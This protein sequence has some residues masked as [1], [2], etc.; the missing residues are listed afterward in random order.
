M[1]QA[2]D[3][4]YSSAHSKSPAETGGNQ[5]LTKQEFAAFFK[6]HYLGF[7]RGNF[8]LRSLLH[9]HAAAVSQICPSI[10][11]TQHVLLP[12]GAQIPGLLTDVAVSFWSATRHQLANKREVDDSNSLVHSERMRFVAHFMLNAVESFAAANQL[13]DR[14]F[15]ATRDNELGLQKKED[16]GSLAAALELR[17]QSFPDF[18]TP[19]GKA[20]YNGEVDLIQLQLSQQESSWQQHILN[21]RPKVLLLQS[22]T[23]ISGYCEIGTINGKAATGWGYP[24][25][26][27]Q[28]SSK[29]DSRLV[30]CTRA[31]YSICSKHINPYGQF[32]LPCVTP[33][34][35]AQ[36][37]YQGNHHSFTPL[38]V[39]HLSKAGGFLSQ[40]EDLYSAAHLVAHYIATP[41]KP[42]Q[43]NQ[44]ISADSWTQIF[45][46]SEDQDICALEL[47]LQKLVLALRHWGQNW[48]LLEA[49][50]V[51]YC[52]LVLEHL[53]LDLLAEYGGSA[54]YRRELLENMMSSSVAFDSM[55]GRMLKSAHEDS[56][57]NSGISY[58]G[59]EPDLLR[60]MT[61]FLQP[62]T[63][64]EGALEESM[65]ALIGGQQLEP[66]KGPSVLQEAE[67]L[68]F[69]EVTYDWLF[70]I[71]SGSVDNDVLDYDCVEDWL[72]SMHWD[73]SH[74]DATILT[75]L[76]QWVKSQCSHAGTVERTVFQ[77]LHRH[78]FG[79]AQG[80]KSP[81]GNLYMGAT[82]HYAWN[83]LLD[84]VYESMV[85][86]RT[87]SL[88][89][90]PVCYNPYQAKFTT[91]KELVLHYI[92]SDGHI[93]EPLRSH[94]RYIKNAASNVER[95]FESTFFVS[96]PSKLSHAHFTGAWCVKPKDFS[97]SADQL[98]ELTTGDT[99]QTLCK[100]DVPDQNKFMYFY[101]G[102]RFITHLIKYLNKP[103]IQRRDYSAVYRLLCTLRRMRQG[104]DRVAM[105]T[106]L[107]RRDQLTTE[108]LTWLP[109]DDALTDDDAVYAA[110][111]EARSVQFQGAIHGWCSRTARGDASVPAE[112]VWFALKALEGYQ[113]A[114]RFHRGEDAKQAL[115]AAEKEWTASAN[116]L[117][118]IVIDG[119][120][121]ASVPPICVA[122]V[123]SQVELAAGAAGEAG[124]AQR[125]DDLVQ[126]LLKKLDSSAMSNPR[127][128]NLPTNI[129]ATMC[130]PQA[131]I[132]TRQTQVPL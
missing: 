81:V 78:V 40:I 75:K 103:D 27:S 38:A 113:K 19:A 118:Q 72:V 101:K 86:M 47:S 43:S 17:H 117:T 71:L 24:E 50:I 8:D 132:K 56:V 13:E 88:H 106:A 15:A 12:E 58:M 39:Y 54:D 120:T 32:L 84:C 5:V 64:M 98:S 131:G 102:D 62:L 41:A 127:K 53:Q 94:Y 29:S 125:N 119:L 107:K 11:S 66:F 105:R 76:K 48:S 126:L 95:I 92:E 67:D 28:L 7:R 124:A 111:V 114:S 85:G 80:V 112:A 115:A 116:K 63:P 77:H 109:I 87:Q 30:D 21:F 128:R 104:A 2:F 25:L 65:D 79:A 61:G 90:F 1:Q 16:A 37:V 91:L 52:A 70:S 46:I 49:P 74:S 33:G 69:A 93:S 122:D 60:A 18:K 35:V 36:S 57:T 6:E 97:Y 34:C 55:I 9:L 100:D 42:K 26:I 45:G 130:P 44:I 23:D 83:N 14:A 99:F 22:A 4:W 20:L 123:R 89:L 10:R 110:L 108:L 82:D 68:L 121:D 31:E 3:A 96:T 73:A 129:S 59:Q 51:Y